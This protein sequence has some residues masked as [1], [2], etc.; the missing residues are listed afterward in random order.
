MYLIGAKLL[1][2]QPF[3]SVRIGVAALIRFPIRHKVRVIREGM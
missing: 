1:G 3:A 2:V